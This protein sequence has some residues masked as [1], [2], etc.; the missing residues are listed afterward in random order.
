MESIK[1]LRTALE[2]QRREARRE[3]SSLGSVGNFTVVPPPSAPPP[4]RPSRRSPSSPPPIPPPWVEPTSDV[5]LD[6]DACP[7]VLH[8]AALTSPYSGSTR[9]APDFFA[10]SCT[11][12]SQAGDVVLMYT[13]AAGSSIRLRQPTND[14][15]SIHELRYGGDCPGENT[16]QCFDDPDR[17]MV[18]WTNGGDAAEDVYYIQTGFY[19]SEGAFTVEWEVTA[20]GEASQWL[21]ELELD[22][23]S[24]SGVLHLADMTSPYTGSTRDA[25][26]FVIPS[27]AAAGN[28]AGDVVLVYTLA[29]GSTI[30]LRQPTNDYDSIHELRYGGDCPGENPVQCFDDPD[31]SM[32][33]WTNGGDA[34]EDVYY[35]QS[36]YADEE[37]LFTV[38]WEV[39]APGEESQWTPEER[40]AKL[41]CRCGHAL[42]CV[43]CADSSGRFVLQPAD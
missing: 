19:A 32:V 21:S 41:E 13:L 36:G 30:R 27:C 34:A 28:L 17:I 43:E 35:I 6:S 11:S 22:S 9:N 18:E 37:G 15:D 31:R 1:K 12:S 33:E 25:F 2:V 39:T 40:Y 16:V 20:P 10:P 14:Y 3:A 24:C 38:E 5:E 23:D 8:L 26:N 7:G 4:S 29:P 42:A